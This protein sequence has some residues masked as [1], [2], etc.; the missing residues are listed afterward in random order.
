MKVVILA[1]GKGTRFDNETI[2]QP[3]P[4]IKIFDKPIIEHIITL[5]VRQ[6]FK[7][8]LIAGG[9]LCEHIVNYFSL[10]KINEIQY[11]NTVND[12][13]IQLIDTGVESTTLERI[14]KTIPFI[15]ED[16]FILTYGDG[17]CDVDMRNVINLHENSSCFITLTA[18]N[19]PGRWG[20]LSFDKDSS[21][22]EFKEKQTKDWINGG[23]MIVD[24]EFLKYSF[25]S[26]EFENE[27]LPLLS[28]MKHVNAFK[29]TGNWQ[30]MD[31]RK[32]REEIEKYDLFNLK[33]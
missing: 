30:C 14:I 28:E 12:I 4:M 9:Y 10:E 6:G 7:D 11:K 27:A 29:H 2:L 31:T 19:P 20:V 22:V 26:K 1:G 24:K 15:T 13:N 23:F 5:F 25:S 18:V 8:F 3:K 17:L 21:I 16:K 32:D 33:G